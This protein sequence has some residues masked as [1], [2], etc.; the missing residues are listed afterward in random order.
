MGLRTHDLPEAGCRLLEC[1]HEVL[2]ALGACT[3]TIT[4]SVH[5]SYTMSAHSQVPHSK[6]ADAAEMIADPRDSNSLVLASCKV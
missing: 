3:I 4:D 1:N 6:Q 5:G 2:Y